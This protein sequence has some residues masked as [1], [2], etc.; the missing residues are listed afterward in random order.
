MNLFL[1]KPLR[2]IAGGTALALVLAAMGGCQSTPP[3]AE[4]AGPG[5]PKAA[6]REAGRAVRAPVFA[7]NAR[8]GFGS[9]GSTVAPGDEDLLQVS[10]ADDAAAK[11]ELLQIPALAARESETGPR[12]FGG[13]SPPTSWRPAKALLALRAQLLELAPQRSKSSDGMVGDRRHWERGDKSDHNP[14]VRDAS[15]LGVVTAYDVT[16]SPSTGCDV[17]KLVNSLVRTRDRRIKYII[18]N[19]RIINRDAV[20]GVGAWTWRTYGGGNPHDKH[21]HLSLLP[22]STHYN[23]TGAWNIAVR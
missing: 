13:W 16:N 17:Q 14:W 2:A 12:A 1:L 15:N 23:D 5:A 11:Q 3:P 21:M 4:P 7:Y 18:W 22:A 8:R 19:H 10:G 6:A 9:S 20:G